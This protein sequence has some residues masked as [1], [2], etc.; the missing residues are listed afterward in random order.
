MKRV[1]IYGGAFN[2]V[3]V[4]H[5]HVVNYILKENIV[6]EVWIVPSY[7]HFHGKQMA[8]HSDRCMMCELMFADMDNVRLLDI[9][10][11][12]SYVYPEYDGSTIEFMKHLR[13]AVDKDPQDFYIIIGQDNAEHMDTWNRGG[14]LIQNEKFIT[15]PRKYEAESE[16]KSNEW[17]LNEPHKYLMR[18]P[19]FNA[20]SSEVRHLFSLVNE[21]GVDDRLKALLGHDVLAYTQHNKLYME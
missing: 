17:Y 8:S 12:F 19:C 7:R 4:G 20:S 6:D 10:S 15:V 18:V 3:H 1:G 16:P 13:K 9:D 11:A 5:K 2:P 21:N 14:E